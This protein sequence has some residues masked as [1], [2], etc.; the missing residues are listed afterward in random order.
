LRCSLAQAWLC[1][2]TPPH[3]GMPAATAAACRLVQV[4]RTHPDLHRLLPEALRLQL[5]AGPMART[6]TPRVAPR[7]AQAQPADPHRRRARGHR[8]D[9]HQTSSRGRAKVVLMHPAEAMNLQSANALLKTLEEPPG[10][11]PAA[12]DRCRPEHCCC[13]R[14]A[15][16]ARWCACAAPPDVARALAADAG[17]GA[18]EV[19][20]AA[21]CAA[22]AGCRWRWPQAGVDAARWA[23]C[24]RRARGQPAAFAGWPLPRVLDAL[25]KL[26]HDGLA[27]CRRRR[28]ALLSGRRRCRGPPRVAPAGGW[29]KALAR[30]A[31]HDRPPLERGPAA[32]RAAVQGAAAWTARLRAGAPIHSAHERQARRPTR[33]HAGPGRPAV[34]RC[35]S[36][37]RPA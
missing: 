33:C 32:R 18:A 7:Q 10:R 16:A 23:A 28:T 2:A 29:S 5:G 3:A 31:R 25:Q 8:L 27:M 26:C 13:P 20:L 19:L 1:E 36:A 6:V 9:R 21:L 24:R 30:L 11:R 4:A 15:A 35:G 17:R 34:R 37:A 14:C 12:A 22:P